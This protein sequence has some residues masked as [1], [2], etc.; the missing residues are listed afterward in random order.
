MNSDA[1]NPFL[2]L[3]TNNDQSET[4]KKATTTE[5]TINYLLERIFLITIDKSKFIY[6]ISNIYFKVVYFL[7]RF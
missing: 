5:S 7:K 1:N 2:L 4:L 3:F 6:Q